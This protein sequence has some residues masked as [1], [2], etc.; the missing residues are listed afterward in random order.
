MGKWISRVIDRA[1]KRKEST[2]KEN[3]LEKKYLEIRKERTDSAD[4]VQVVN[5]PSESDMERAQCF[6]D[7]IDEDVPA[8]QPTTLLTHTNKSNPDSSPLK[9]AQADSSP[10][11]NQSLFPTS[12]KPSSG[13]IKRY[14]KYKNS[15][16]DDAN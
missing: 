15:G 4:I 12:R 13:L 7:E 3:H 16:P 9:S 2:D 8:Q 1:K 10:S 11:E 6:S 5:W 14:E